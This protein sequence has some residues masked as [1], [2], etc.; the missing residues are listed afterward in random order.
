MEPDAQLER[1]RHAAYSAGREAWPAVPYE[2][3]RFDNWTIAQQIDARALGS[4]GP[5]LF[6]ASSCADGY[7]EAIA[8]FESA[9]VQKIRPTIGRAPLA[10]EML[11]EL[12]QTLRV[13]VLTGPSPKI[14]HYKGSGPLGVWVRV[15]AT[16]IALELKAASARPTTS[17]SAVMDALVA[18]QT[19][20]E[21]A[22]A[23]LQHRDLFR[24]QLENCLRELAPREKALLRLHFLDRLSIDQMGIILRVHRSTVARWLIALRRRIVEQLCARMAI[25]IRSGSAIESLIRSVW[26]DIELSVDRLLETEDLGRGPHDAAKLASGRSDQRSVGSAT[27]TEPPTPA[28][29]P[30]DER[31]SAQQRKPIE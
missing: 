17:D 23:K 3:A 24:T 1:L 27:P 14:G 4:Y 18:A 8:A 12:R 21:L 28:A 6:L 25:E 2:R 11:D 22:A 29:E 15:T 19:S 30:S 16:R 20:P 13:R 9:Y 26:D 7:P 31:R 10:P 5:D